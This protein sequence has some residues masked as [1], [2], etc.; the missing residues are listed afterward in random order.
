MKKMDHVNYPKTLKNKSE[1][2]IRFIAKDAWEAVDAMP[3]GE[4]VSY[5]LDEICYCTDELNRRAWL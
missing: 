3:E 2:Q 4:N 5:Y 1:D